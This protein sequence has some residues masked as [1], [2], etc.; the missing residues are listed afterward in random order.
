VLRTLLAAAARRN[1]DDNQLEGT[2]PFEFS[3]LAALTTL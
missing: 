1:L 2:V 3:E